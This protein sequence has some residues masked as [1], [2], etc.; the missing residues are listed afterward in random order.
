MRW[1][2]DLALI[3]CVA[4][5][6]AVDPVCAVE[7]GRPV[8]LTFNAETQSYDFETASVAGS[9]RPEGAYHGVSRL[10]HKASGTQ[11]IDSRYSALNLFRIFSVNLGLGTP[12]YWTGEISASDDAVEIFWPETDAHQGT[13]RAR[14][15]VREPGD[16]DLT[17]T[18]KSL[19]T[20]AGYEIL[21]PNY[22]DQSMIPHVYLKRREIGPAP[23]E[24]D[25]V[26]PTVSDVFRGCGLVFPRDAHTARFPVDGR[27]NRSEYKMDV[28]PFL[29]L[30]HYGHPFMFMTDSEKRIAAVM[31]MRRE[32]CSAISSRY[33]SEKPED[34][35]TSY[36]A[37]DFLIFGRN[38][39]PGDEATARIRL[40]LTDL[41][42][43]MSQPVELHERFLSETPG[44]ND[45]KAQ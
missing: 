11:V 22:F 7:R 15:E 18:F 33:Y 23:P 34:R 30:R 25:L 24:I 3:L 21:L 42:A 9:I 16:V 32:D 40:S 1:R 6:V 10:V 17:L 38:F 13:I 35:S 44:P 5:G 26:V 37:M 12:R 4:A 45:A 19:G 8:T 2:L 28:A 27:W 41:D 14:Y 43:E 20:Y 39:V 31:M 29:P 36:S